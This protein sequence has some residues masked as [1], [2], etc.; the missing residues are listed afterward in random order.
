MVFWLDADVIIKEAIPEQFLRDLLPEGAYAGYFGR[1]DLYTETGFH[2]LDARHPA[3]RMFLTEWRKVYLDGTI[4][5][6][7]QW[8]DCKAY[9]FVREQF[10]TA[11]VKFE[12]LSGEFSTKG[13][14]IAY[15]K[16]GRYL[17]HCKGPRRKAQGYSEEREE[18]LG[19]SSV[20]GDAERRD[21]STGA[22]S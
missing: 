16:L 20:L 9:D 10:E 15:S 4:F 11:G 14:P 22:I 6:L 7:G 5:R 18:A 13:H 17:D 21:T 1:D 12:N 8:H 19:L 2:V 3:H